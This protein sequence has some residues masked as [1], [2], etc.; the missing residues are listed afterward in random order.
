MI[1]HDR[2]DLLSES[3][4]TKLIEEEGKVQNAANE[5]KALLDT[6]GEDPIVAEQVKVTVFMEMV[7]HKLVAQIKIINITTSI[8]KFIS[9]DKQFLEKVDNYL[10]RI[11][12]DLQNRRKN[13][14]LNELNL[15]NSDVETVENYFNFSTK[16]Y[17]EAMNAATEATK[18][19]KKANIS[20]FGLF[21]FRESLYYME[22]PSFYRDNF[23][24]WRYN[25]NL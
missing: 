4:F 7:A 1:A 20:E 21:T 8:G 24:V 10:K 6:M 16:Y 14:T 17:N 18:A 15:D 22:Y 13:S 9:R 5:A 2:H 25:I 19:R 3:A 11:L 12:P 23:M